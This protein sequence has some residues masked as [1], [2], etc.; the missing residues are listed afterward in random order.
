MCIMF[1]F[2][3]KTH[4]SIGKLVNLSK[5]LQNA[6]TILFKLIIQSVTSLKI[7]PRGGERRAARRGGGGGWQQDHHNRTAAAPR[8][9]SPAAPHPHQARTFVRSD[10]FIHIS[11]IFTKF[12]GASLPSMCV[13]LV[14]VKQCQCRVIKLF[15]QNERHRRQ[16]RRRKGD[17]RED[18]QVC[19]RTLNS[20]ARCLMLINAPTLV[21]FH[22]VLQQL[23]RN[24]IN[25]FVKFIEVTFYF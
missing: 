8:R 22:E 19:K 2:L 5:R 13:K 10:Q 7:G 14:N 15:V 1:F 21:K 23:R 17:H 4:S 3:H 18:R 25:K 20:F 11:F 24:F 9:T 16:R 12:K 6:Q